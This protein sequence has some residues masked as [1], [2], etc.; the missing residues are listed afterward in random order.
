[1]FWQTTGV[2]RRLRAEQGAAAQ[3]LLDDDDIGRLE[4]LLQI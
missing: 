2:A 1:M 3:R 4:G